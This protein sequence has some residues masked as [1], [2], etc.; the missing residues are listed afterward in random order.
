MNRPTFARTAQRSTL[1]RNAGLPWAD[2]EDKLLKTRFAVM[3]EHGF[4]MDAIVPAL[5]RV[6][7]RTPPG[8]EARIE[9]LRLQARVGPL[10]FDENRFTY[11]SDGGL[12]ADASELG[13][14]PG[15]LPELFTLRTNLAVEITMQR[16]SRDQGGA[17]YRGHAG[18]HLFTATIF[19]D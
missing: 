11:D 12:C 3:V 5:A 7:G 1:P 4:P 6:H 2:R 16:V 14:K 13:I 15:P 17:R 19:N 8:I 9:F 10:T 18:P